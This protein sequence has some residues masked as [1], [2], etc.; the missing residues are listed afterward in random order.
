MRFPRSTR[1][2]RGQLDVA[3]FL[4]VIFLMAFALMLRDFLVLPRGT[5]LELPGAASASAASAGE[6]W[7]IVAMDASRRLYFENQVTD[8][9]QLVNALERR[10]A[11]RGAGATLLIQA[12]RSLPYGDLTELAARVRQ[13]GVTRVILGVGRGAAAESSP[14]P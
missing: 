7:W 11:A 13:A 14:R 10:V 4:C 12:D 3:P 9:D 1:L 6:S 8:L 5:R 2:F